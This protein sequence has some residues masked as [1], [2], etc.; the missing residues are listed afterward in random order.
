MLHTKTTSINYF[1]CFALLTILLLSPIGSLAQ[2]NQEEQQK[3]TV[4]TQKITEE[5]E[6]V[7]EAP[8]ERPVSTVTR[9]DKTKIENIKPLDLSEVIRYAPGA[10]V[11]FGDKSTYTLKLRGMDAK[12]IAL[13]IDGIPTYEPY[14][15]SFDLKNIATEGIDSLQLTKGPSSVLYGPNTMGGIVNVITQ[16]PADKPIFSLN[17]SLGEHSTLHL[18]VQTGFRWKRL[19]FAGNMNYQKSNG[20]DYPEETTGKSLERSNTEY[21]RTNINAKLLYNPN[22]NTEILLKGGVFLS[23]YSMPPGLGTSKPRYWRFKNWDRYDLNVGG[24]TALGAN[25]TLRFRAYYISYKNTLNMF[26]DAQLTQMRFESTFDNA[27][28]GLFALSDL[29][30]SNTNQLKFSLNVKG[31]IART[32]DD[33][34]EPWREFDQAT[35]SLA[36]ED[37]FA[38]ASQWKLVGGLSFDALNKF[39]GDTTSRVNPLVGL[40]FSPMNS[41]DLHVSY[42]YKSRFPTMRSMYSSSSGN[43]DLLSESG[44]NLEL[45]FTYQKNFYIT[46]AVFFTRFKDMIDSLR[47]AEYDFQRI[48][49]NVAKAYINGFEMQVQKS[50]DWTAATL[51][52]TYLNHRNES[53]DRPLD[54]LPDHNLSFDCQIYPFSKLRLGLVGLW[55]SSSSWLDFN[56]GELWE[57]PSYF[58]LDSVAALRFS[59]FEVFIKVTN[60]LNQF[61]YTEPGFPWRE[62]YIEFGFK[63]NI[64][65]NT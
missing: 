21:K 42:A 41:L 48:Y 27:V 60:I 10:T 15:S 6:V 38:I 1:L 5:I 16:R 54:A 28:Y 45:G 3:K 51:N 20:F 29:H 57:I 13:L 12:R 19:S 39:I 44:T 7:A 8:K 56:S 23:N 49:F 31:D 47:L 55:A 65:G 63:T 59:Q 24:F 37:H 32:Q 34:G 40:K 26:K 2:E 64:L 58:N 62:R 46:G 61:I 53:D 33:V 35:F 14:Y 25:S 22:D 50:F 52:Y 17:S 36:V 4:K 11:T 43:P 9:L 18:G 30:L